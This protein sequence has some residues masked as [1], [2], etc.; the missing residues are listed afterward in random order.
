MKFP[1]HLANKSQHAMI[2][3]FSIENF[4]S[5]RSEQTLS[6]VASNRHSGSHDTHAVAIPNAD[7]R[8]LK[9]AVLYGANGAGKSNVFKALK[10]LRSIA[11]YP[12]AKNSGTGRDVFRFADTGID[13]SVFDLQFI[14]D[15]QL[16]RFGCKLDNDR[17]AEEWLVKC[18]GGREKMLYE[19]VTT[20]SG[21]VRIES[22]VFKSISEKL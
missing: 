20:E 5:F 22:A 17:V 12:R 13:P 1:I 9:T 4:R 19:R 15:E 21:E 7:E 10:Y 14:V 16:Y 8:V 2:V 3:S 11:V 6:L 18:V